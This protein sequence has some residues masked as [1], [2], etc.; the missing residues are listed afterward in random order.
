MSLN[1][2]SCSVCGNGLRI[3]Y[4][5]ELICPSCNGLKIK[6][7]SR[8]LSE[9]N[10]S[11]AE[12]LRNF[13][14]LIANCNYS[15]TLSVIL[16]LRENVAEKLSEMPG[17]EEASRIWI[18]CLY[19]LANLPEEPK[20]IGVVSPNEVL[21]S[22]NQVMEDISAITLCEQDKIV[23]LENGVKCQTEVQVLYRLPDK[24]YDKIL[25]ELG[26]KFIADTKHILEEMM[27]ALMIKHFDLV[28]SE[29][30]SRNLRASFPRYLLPYNDV[31]KIRE[32]VQVAYGISFYVANKLGTNFL[33]KRGLLQMSMQDFLILKAQITKGLSFSAVDIFSPPNLNKEGDN[34]ALHIFVK[35]RQR[36]IVYLPYHSLVLLAKICHKY[37]LDTDEYRKSIGENPEDWIFDLIKGHL[38]TTTP[39]GG[40]ELHRFKL[41][42]NSGEIDA[43][44]YNDKKI[45]IVESKFRETL[46]VSELETEL[47]KFEKTVGNFIK[48]KER[49]GFSNSQEVISLFY[50]PWPPFPTFGKTGITLIPTISTLIWYLQSNFPQENPKFVKTTD[51]INDFLN[52]DSTERL[53]MTD[54]SN[55]LDVE[56]EKY[57]VQDVQI[58][59]ISDD[60]V[61]AYAFSPIGRAFPFTFDID[62]DCL[63][64]IELTGVKRGSVIRACTYNLNGNWTLIQLVDFRIIYLEKQLDPDRILT[65]LNPKQYEEFLAHYNT[66][67]GAEELLEIVNI[68]NI[69]LKKY[70]RWAENKGYNIN[71][72]I[73]RLMGMDSGPGHKLT[74]CECGNVLYFPEYIYKKVT[75]QFGSSLKCKDCDSSLFSKI[76]TSVGEKA[77]ALLT[78]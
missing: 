62:E 27:K 51:P 73:G 11:L 2:L 48:R 25:E 47:K 70:I 50:N 20:S 8:V 68:N 19:L 66:G 5:S 26:A 58:A 71:I 76:L 75:K 63:K 57:R 3:F 33:S 45:V 64:K 35:D 69:D 10:D 42:G 54:L 14:I 34:L 38:E 7:K 1:S 65:E 21:A 39:I 28:N 22:A 18:T 61:V 55:F 4:E 43:A 53:Y 6:E 46:T 41:S 36:N 9:L 78:Y 44:G 56:N 15:R 49:Y 77:A 29:A 32:L 31:N 67:R 13:K 24:V 37:V 16:E 74:Q 59:D 17:D 30:L 60:E 52:N 40:R 72:A 23:Y 12:D